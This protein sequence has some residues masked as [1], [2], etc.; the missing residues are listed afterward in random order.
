MTFPSS[1][2]DE[3]ENILT[4]MRPYLWDW[5]R[6]LRE[7][8]IEMEGWWD[9]E[10]AWLSAFGFAGSAQRGGNTEA[11]EQRGLFKHVRYSKRICVFDGGIK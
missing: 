3:M 8:K 7:V 2:G 11:R 5:R 6:G 4:F 9:K 10:T 1:I